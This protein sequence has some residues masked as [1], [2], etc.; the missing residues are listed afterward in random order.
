MVLGSPKKFEAYVAKRLDGKP[1]LP[2]SELDDTWY[3]SMLVSP[4]A[5]ES[6]HVVLHGLQNQGEVCLI[7]YLASI[8]S[9]KSAQD[10]H[11]Q[12]SKQA[13]KQSKSQMTNKLISHTDLDAQQTKYAEK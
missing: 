12:S 6:C 13:S 2:A 4:A 11:F 1:G 8:F 9:L 10:N 7:T 3:Y 5:F